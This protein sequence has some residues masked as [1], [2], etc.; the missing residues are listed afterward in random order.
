MKI[1]LGIT[2]KLMILFFFFI[3]IFYGTLLVL[4]VN[5]QKLMETSQQIVSI[6]NQVAALSKGM[7][8]S[9][10]NM[11]VNDKKFRLL[12]KEVYRDYF[13]TAKKEFCEE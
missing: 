5:V 9:L 11:D 2:S 1:T 7:L 8:E 6:N 13:E 12:K 4:F 3:F 10:I